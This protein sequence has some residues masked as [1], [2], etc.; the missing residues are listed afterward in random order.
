[1]GLSRFSSVP[2]VQ[3][4]TTA[5]LFAQAWENLLWVELGFSLTVGLE[6]GC[7]HLVQEGCFPAELSSNPNVNTPEPANQGLTRQTRIFQV[8]LLELVVAKLYRT[9]AL[10][11]RVWTPLAYSVLCLF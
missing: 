10:Q 9:V 11:D 6:Q 1:M 8:G 7:P 3:A 5:S 4:R 2:K